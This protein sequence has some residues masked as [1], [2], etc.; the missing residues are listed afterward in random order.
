MLF[1][2]NIIMFQ[3]YTR[4]YCMRKLHGFN[5]DNTILTLFYHSIVQSVWSYC[6]VCWGGNTTKADRQR[7]DQIVRKASKIIEVEQPKVDSV[8]HCLLGKV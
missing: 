2:A 3:R 8:Y 1:Y 5:V 7:I 4:M 6:L